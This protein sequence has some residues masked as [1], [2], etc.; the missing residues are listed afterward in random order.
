M[1]KMMAYA[2]LQQAYGQVIN[3]V[4]IDIL[5]EQ[6]DEV[7]LAEVSASLADSVS[8]VEAVLDAKYNGE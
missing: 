5:P 6:I 8:S 4:G 1:R 2:Q 7:P 3:T